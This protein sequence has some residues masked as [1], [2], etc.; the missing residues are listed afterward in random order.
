M[1][2][3]KTKET[4]ESVSGFIEK[5]SDEARKKDCKLVLRLM[6]EAT[7]AKPKMWGDS[8]VGFGRYKYKYASGREGEWFV[9]GFSPRK[10]DLTLYIFPGLDAY[11]DLMK[12]LGKHKAS[13]SCLHIKKLSDVDINVLKQI[14]NESVKNMADQRIDKR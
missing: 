9:T 12:Q 7:K 6:K 2:E 4:E 14:I 13:K 8:I 11:D 10:N 5:I 1:A 3:L